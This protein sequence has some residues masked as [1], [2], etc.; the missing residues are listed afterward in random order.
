[1]DCPVLRPLLP[2]ALLFST[3]CVRKTI[4]NFTTQRVVPTAMLT[5][6][7]DRVCKVGEALGHPLNSVTHRSPHRAMVIADA[8]AAICDEVRAWEA[9]TDGVVARTVASP[10]SA[11]IAAVKD[12][13][14]VERRFR[15]RAALRFRSAWEH[16]NQQFGPIGLDST[17]PR[18]RSKDELTLLVGLVSGTLAMIH[19]KA[20]GGRNH[21][22]LD[23]LARVGRAAPCLD[24]ATWWHVPSALQAA[25]WI[26]V[27]GSGPEG[28]DPWEQLHTAAVAGE[29]SGVRLGWALYAELAANSGEDARVHE[30]IEAASRSYE[31]TESNADYAMLDEYSRSILLHESDRIWAAERG[32]RTPVFGQLPAEPLPIEPSEDDPF[33][34]DPF[35]D[36]PSEE[37]SPEDPQ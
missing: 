35:G 22:P 33:A 32:H 6:D 2:L 31:H 28:V 29:S 34:E 16:S 19:D 36:D 25:A 12:R 27:P 11:R 26:V 3:G 37:E 9:Q 17:C 5:A 24:D 4:D 1:M 13:L 20:S 14:A 10:G 7:V 23:T 18:V 8:T 30:A 15:Q 21:V